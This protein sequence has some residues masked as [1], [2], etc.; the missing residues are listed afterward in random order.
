M[1]SFGTGYFLTDPEL[2]DANGTVVC[3]FRLAVNEYRSMN[4]QKVKTRH[5]FDFEAWDSAAKTIVDRARKGDKLEYFAIPRQHK[6]P[7]PDG[8]EHSKVVFRVSEFQIVQR[9][10]YNDDEDQPE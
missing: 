1:K 4:G 7:G 9:T 3:N 6:W 5:Y 2:K 8:H 10:E